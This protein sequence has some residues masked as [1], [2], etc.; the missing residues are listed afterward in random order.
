MN[1]EVIWKETVVASSSRHLPGEAGKITKNI[2]SDRF[3]M[4]TSQ[5]RLE[6]SR[7]ANPLSVVNFRITKIL[8]AD[9]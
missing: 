4:G 3:E 6:R 2:S 8:G 7:W 5:T 1:S 9:K